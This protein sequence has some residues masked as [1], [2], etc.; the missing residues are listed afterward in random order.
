MPYGV[1]VDHFQHLI[2]ANPA[3]SP[4]ERAEMWLEM[5]RT[6]LPWRQYGDLAHP[7]SGRF[8]QGQLHIYRFP[9]YFIDYALALTVALQ[10]WE[11]AARDRPA[12]MEKYMEL[13]RL[14]GELAFGELVGSVGLVSPFEDGCLERVA[15]HAR[16]KIE[17]PS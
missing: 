9:F 16:R 10:L 11:L 1:A 3:A 2:Y 13:C 14:G 12:A 7:A 4:D 17:A 15:E 8:W 5:E 6:Y